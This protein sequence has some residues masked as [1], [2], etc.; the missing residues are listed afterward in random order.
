MTPIKSITLN[1]NPSVRQID[2]GKAVNSSNRLNALSRSSIRGGAEGKEEAKGENTGDKKSIF[3]TA[4]NTVT[5]AFSSLFWL[6]TAGWCC[7]L[8]SKA[9]AGAPETDASKTDTSNAK[10]HGEENKSEA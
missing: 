8:C 7:G 6:L 3:T 4:W 9:K 2:L 10:V 1:A 5:W